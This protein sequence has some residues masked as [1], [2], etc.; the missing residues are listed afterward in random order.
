MG[1]ECACI[2]HGELAE[3]EKLVRQAISVRQQ[4][5]DRAGTAYALERLGTILI[6]LGRFEESHALMTDSLALYRQLGIR[7]RQPFAGLALAIVKLSQGNM[8][9]QR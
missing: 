5:G 8:R 2:R 9:P 6:W 1:G 4:T 3:G 7:G